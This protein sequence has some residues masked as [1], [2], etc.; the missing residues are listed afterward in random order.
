M[1]VQFALKSN[2][3]YSYMIEKIEKDIINIVLIMLI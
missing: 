3:M 1:C 2:Q